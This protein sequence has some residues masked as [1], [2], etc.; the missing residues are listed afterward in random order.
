MQE[1]IRPGQTKDK[2][3]GGK[4]KVVDSG[5]KS[6]TASNTFKLTLSFIVSNYV[7]CA[8]AKPDLNLKANLRDDFK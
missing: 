7:Q 5:E 8:T 2:T 1:D 4:G 3:N 6:F